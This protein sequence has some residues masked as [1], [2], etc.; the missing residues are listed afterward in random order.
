MAIV[1]HKHRPVLRRV[2]I[3][4]DL[5]G[6]LLPQPRLLGE[7]FARKSGDRVPADLDGTVLSVDICLTRRY[8]IRLVA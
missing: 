2:W 3:L 1:A 5:L 4:V 8:D 6:D 7:P